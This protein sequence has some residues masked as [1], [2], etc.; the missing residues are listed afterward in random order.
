MGLT[1]ENN[2]IIQKGNIS[3]AYGDP[4]KGFV[5]R[6]NIIFENEYGFHGDG[7]GT[8][9][10]ALNKYFPGGLIENN[11]IV[12][13]SKNV[14]GRDNFYP[15]SIRQIGFANIETYALSNNNPYKSRGTDGKQIGADIDIS[16]IGGN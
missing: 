7:A 1:I 12:G 6:N 8:G 10:R 9:K 5:F 2:T 4:I 3:S 14:Y 15:K 11:I 13:G 16:K